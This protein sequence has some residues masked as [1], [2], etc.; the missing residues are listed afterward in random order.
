[1]GSLFKHFKTQINQRQGHEYDFQ[2]AH[3]EILERPPAPWVGRCAAVISVAFVLTLVWACWGKLDILAQANGKLIVSSHSKEIQV[4]QAGEIA[5]IYVE[6]GTRVAKGQV[7]LSLTLANINAKAE[8]IDAQIRFRRQ[9]KAKYQALLTDDPLKHFSTLAVG[10]AGADEARAHLVSLW[11]EKLKNLEQIQAELVVNRASQNALMEELGAIE[12]LE[13]NIKQRIAASESL[14]KAKQLARMSLLEQEAELLRSRSDK[15]EKDS[16]LQILK[17][18]EHRLSVQRDG[19]LARYK[20]E[21]HD[22]LSQAQA[23]LDVLQQ[24]ALQVAEQQ[25]LHSVVAPVDGVVQE[26]AVHT[27]GGVVQPGQQ[28]MVIVPNSGKIEAEVMLLNKDIGFVFAG[29]RVE[30]KLDAFPYTRYGTIKGVLEHVSPDAV[31]HEQLGLV[32]P[33]KVTLASNQIQV[34]QSQVPLQPGMSVSVEVLT[35]DRRVIDY[36]LSPIQQYQSEALK[37]R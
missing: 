2:P 32:F 17:A 22:K 9:E 23:S 33:A 34:E 10:E 5:A 1:M 26:L 14:A 21:T 19:V 6:N 16:R 15:A 27:L 8:E 18:Q 36:F 3:L 13:A 35:G 11:Q 37:E 4:A 12:R 31:E 28:L 30:V 24:Q 20:K 25:R 29:Q 7:L